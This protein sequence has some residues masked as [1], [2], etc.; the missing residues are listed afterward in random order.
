MFEKLLSSFGV[1]NLKVDT[2]VKG[3]K[4]NIH[5]QLTGTIYIKGGSTEEVIDKIEL[6]LIEKIENSA[7]TSDFQILENEVERFEIKEL[8]KIGEKENY[9]QSFT[10]KVNTNDLK[11]HP[12]KL[13]LKTHVYLVSSID[14]Y[15]EDEIKVIYR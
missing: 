9:K 12:K 11:H 15:D 13:V 5:G 3:D 10:F 14:N 8:I 6:T 7:A 4:F 1:S 2:K